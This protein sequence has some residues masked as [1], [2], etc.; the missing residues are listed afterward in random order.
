MPSE[1]K[2]GLGPFNPMNPY[3]VLTDSD[4]KALIDYD[5][6]I[7][8]M[9]DALR[10]LSAGT[11]IAPPR[12]SLHTELGSLVFTAGAATGRVRALGFRV[13]DTFAGSSTDTDQIVAIFDPDR[14]R[15]AGVIIG[16]LIGGM[17]TGALGGVAVK[18]LAR[19]DAQV[20]ALVGAGFQARSQLR[21]AFAVRSFRRV[22]IASRTRSAALEL[23]KEVLEDYRV[24]CSVVDSPKEAVQDA[25]VV[26][27]A[28]TSTTP[29]I[30]AGWIKAG[31]HV[32]TVGPKLRDAHE[33]P[34]DIGER[35][36]IVATDSPAQL[37]AYDRFFLYTGPAPIG[38]HQIIAKPQRGR[39]DS[40]QITL[41]CS[42]GLAGTEVVLGNEVL[43]RAAEL[44][45]RAS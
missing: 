36:A 29:V 33:L 40:R 22:V 41:Y 42:V 10:E 7:A 12:C 1:P 38:L 21:A 35:C 23:R 27:C 3:L 28:T 4:V 37:A 11:L 26:F 44:N 18:Y 13:Y 16:G 20:L 32:T 17:R 14:A 45:S 5:V 43:R 6:A 24:E 15:L 31:A 9:E 8:A 39:T 25:D 19:P 34:S 30:E 2:D